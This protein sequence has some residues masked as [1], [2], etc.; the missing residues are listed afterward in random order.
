[1]KLK[2]QN[3]QYQTDAVN[4]VADIF[5][6]QQNRSTRFSISDRLE[7]ITQSGLG[8]GNKLTITQSDMLIN[9]NRIQVRNKLKK[10]RDLYPFE[11]IG[12]GDNQFTIEMETGTG[13]TYV[14]TKTIFEL[15]LRYGFTKFIIVVPSV[16]IREGVYKSLQV[17]REHFGE[18]YNNRTFI[19]SNLYQIYAY[20]KN[21]D[22]T[23]T[24]NVAGVLLYAMT[25]E[26]ITPNEDMFIGGNRISLKTLD[27]SHDW[28]SITEDLDSLCC[29]LRS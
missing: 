6:G 10:T 12:E 16:A 9:M 11:P 13:K 27:L 1:M 20:V 19:S 18:H 14:Y 5:N 4:A 21:S 28:Q 25:D 26:A 3:N 22:S 15:N 17:T 24:G 23:S 8:I 7:G 2:F 29:W